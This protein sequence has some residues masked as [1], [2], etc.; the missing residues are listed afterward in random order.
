MLES[1]GALNG[2]VIENEPKFNFVLGS[3]KAPRCIETAIQQMS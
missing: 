2:Q 1:G 3:D